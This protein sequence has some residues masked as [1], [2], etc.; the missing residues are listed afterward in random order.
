[1]LRYNSNSISEK[2]PDVVRRPTAK[3]KVEPSNSV[4][5]WDAIDE[6]DDVSNELSINFI[7]QTHHK[8]LQSGAQDFKHYVNREFSTEK[9]KTGN[10]TRP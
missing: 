4:E 1:M 3:P 10:P 7:N 8:A 9:V 2:A 5:D 6:V